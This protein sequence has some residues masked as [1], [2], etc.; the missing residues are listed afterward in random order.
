MNPIAL[1]G[2]AGIG[3]TSIALSVLHDDRIKKRFG[4]NRRLIRCDQFPGSPTHFL[5]RLSKVIGAGVENP[6]DLECLEPLLS[7][8]D[9][10]IVLDCAEA[11][12]G[13]QGM[14]GREVYGIMDGLCRFKTICLC[15]TSR[16]MIFPLN[17]TCLKVPT[18]SMEAACGIF[19]NIYDCGGRSIPIEGLLQQLEFDAPSVGL[20]AT[21]AHDNAWDCDRLA[22]EWDQHRAQVLRTDRAA[23]IEFLLAS[24]AFRK[25]GPSARELLGV[26]AFFPQGVDERNLEWFF[27]T[28]SNRKKIFD[29]L[30]SLSLT[31]RSDGFI[32]M[33]APIRDYL[34]PQDPKSSTLLCAVKDC[35]FTRLSVDPSRSQ[36]ELGDAQWVQSE[37]MNIE[38]LLGV[39]TSIDPNAV[40]VWDACD[41]FMQHLYWQKPLQIV[42]KPKVEDLPDHHPSKPRCLFQ[43][44][45]LFGLSGDYR[46]QKSLLTHTSTLER[47][48]GDDSRVALTSR[49]LAHVNRMLGCHREGIPQAKEALEIFKRLG[50]TMGQ[51]E[52]FNE[53]ALLL[54]HDDQLDAAEDSSLRAIGFLPEKGQEYLFSR[55][56]HIL[57]EIYNSKGEKEKAIDHFRTALRIA[58]P[59][60]WQHELFWIHYTLALLLSTKDEFDDANAHIVQAKSCA[61]DNAFKRGRAT[62]A[63]AWIWYRECR[64]ED[65]KSEVSSAVKIY[66][67]PGSGMW[68]DVEICKELFKMIEEAMGIPDVASGEFSGYD[69]ALR[70]R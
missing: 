2:A 63:Q 3:K 38:C 20:L 68:Q 53:L 5:A 62:N 55:S 34:H 19:Y 35:Y 7:S 29:K 37:D 21:T 56:H 59:F 8:T 11:V 57:G 4:D 51:A 17:C 15:I 64:L 70:P 39:F 65:A 18:L 41:H 43:L 10:L 42:L 52:C 54:L 58:S 47:E 25:L 66:E 26:V 13:P 61:A 30:C 69:V 36:P 23:T 48:R 40:D 1:I 28:I 12:L 44:S 49:S 31:Y 45:R 16:I 67:T 60:D 33:L 24:P 14:N 9:M 46:E 27:P 6:E 22:K 32:T 50:D